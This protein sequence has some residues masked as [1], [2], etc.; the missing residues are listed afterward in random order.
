MH[1]SC[2]NLDDYH[3]DNFRLPSSEETDDDFAYRTLEEKNQMISDIKDLSN[4]QDT[5][6]EEAVVGFDTAKNTP[7]LSEKQS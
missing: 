6:V 4:W 7:G 5:L 3:P 2:D 1:T